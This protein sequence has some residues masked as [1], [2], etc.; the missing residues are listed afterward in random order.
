DNPMERPQSPEDLMDS[1]T[2]SED[3]E[4]TSDRQLRNHSILQKPK[5]FEDHI[6]EEESYLDDYNPET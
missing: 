4:S 3:P 5:R 1:E 6:M 2:D